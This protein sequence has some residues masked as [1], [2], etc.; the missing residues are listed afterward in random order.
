MRIAPLLVLASALTFGSLQPLPPLSWTCPMHPEVVDDRPGICPICRMNLEPVRLD[1]IWSCPVHEVITAAAPGRCR[2][3]GREMV[4]VTVAV[5]WTCGDRPGVNRLE[6]GRCA[7]GTM[8]QAKYTRRPHGNHNPQHGGQ[9]FMAPDNWHHL[10]GIYPK[11]GVFRLHVYDDYSKPLS[12]VQLQRVTGKVTTTTGEAPLALVRGS[13]FLEARI[14]D[15]ALPLAI[16]AQVAFTPGGPENRFD[17]T[18]AEYSRDDV[19]ATD[20]VRLKADPTYGTGA[21]SPYMVSGFSRTA[22]A[23]AEL[24]NRA[25]ELKEIVDR[26]AFGELYVPAFAAKDLALAIEVRAAEG[27]TPVSRTAIEA[28]TSRLV[29]AAW[30]LDAAGD[31]GN[32]DDVRDAYTRFAAALSELEGAIAGASR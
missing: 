20:D 12:P 30:M 8:A 27:A 9:F 28:A 1:T 2:I 26:G 7:D 17:F 14:G 25:R 23:L 6:P 4:H 31:L 11:A 24:R 19:R 21:R 13:G 10:E 3:C 32:R 22:D 29:R 18:F 5:T 15:A 16:T